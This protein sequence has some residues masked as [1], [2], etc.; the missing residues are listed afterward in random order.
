MAATC[1]AVKP[2]CKMK[3][4]C[5]EIMHKDQS[6]LSCLDLLPCHTLIVKDDPSVMAPWT[7]SIGKRS[8]YSDMK[9]DEIDAKIEAVCDECDL[10][11][12]D[13][14]IVKMGYVQLDAKVKDLIVKGTLMEHDWL[15]TLAGSSQIPSLSEMLHDLKACVPRE[16]NEQF[17][18][19]I[20]NAE[21]SCKISMMIQDD[22]NNVNKL[23]KLIDSAC[24]TTV[25]LLMTNKVA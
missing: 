19:V 25:P 16:P 20:N 24:T 12:L 1:D 13:T 18:W 9:L 23:Q 11:R 10:F 6:E 17:E 14:M 21:T 2:D 5:D 22:E 15:I 7:P 4:Q 8:V 3:Q